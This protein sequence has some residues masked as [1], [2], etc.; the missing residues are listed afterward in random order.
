M[1]LFLIVFCLIFFVL[2]YEWSFTR[3][4]SLIHFYSFCAILILFTGLRYKVGIDTLNYMD[5]YVYL[6]DLYSLISFEYDSNG[7]NY[8][9]LL[10]C[11]FAKFLG[12]DFFWLQL[13]QA[14]IV[15]S[16]V[17]S[18]IRKYTKY[19]YTALLLYVLTVYLHYNIE[20]MRE[21][22]AISFF[23]LSIKYYINKKWL[24]YY[25]VILGCI[26]F[27]YSALFLLL[28]PFFSNL[29]LNKK[30]FFLALVVWVISC[31]LLPQ[32][33]QIMTIFAFNDSMGHKVNSYFG[34]TWLSPS[35]SFQVL[36]LFSMSIFPTLLLVI[37][38]FFRLKSKLEPFMC[39]YIL[40]GVLS[41]N[42]PICLRLSNY[43]VLI[44][45]V[46]VTNI[47][48]FVVKHRIFKSLTYTVSLI[49]V[50]VC[51]LPYLGKQFTNVGVDGIYRYHAW[52]PYHS[53][54][55]P[56]TEVKRKIYYDLNF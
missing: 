41:I 26:L 56:Q 19:K 50:L 20:I 4:C 39:M 13:L 51:S 12:K 16:I 53:I 31:I 54:F 42:I 48:A 25:I 40:L 8:F 33:T 44:Y 46:Y 9:Y 15:N 45:V 55:D 14:F 6:P 49:A 37:S 52:Y 5:N 21:A 18:F 3:S 11:S 36:Q 29:R 30:F 38:S 1:I 43:F 7:Y 27:H 32:L 17:L 47:I 35:F 10:L 28:L 34:E 24:K 2:Q 22:I 23:L